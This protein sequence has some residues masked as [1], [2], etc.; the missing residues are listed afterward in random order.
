ML[1]GWLAVGKSLARPPAR[2]PDGHIGPASRGQAEHAAGGRS[3][4]APCCSDRVRPLRLLLGALDPP[5]VALQEQLPAH[6]AAV[7]G[8]Q[9]LELVPELPQQLPVH[10]AQLQQLNLQELG[11]VQD[12]APPLAVD[13]LNEFHVRGLELRIHLVCEDF[14]IVPVHEEVGEGAQGPP[15]EG[16]ADQRVDAREEDVP[17][18]PCDGLQASSAARADRKVEAHNEIPLLGGQAEDDPDKHPNEKEGPDHDEGGVLR[19]EHLHLLAGPPRLVPG[20]LQVLD[21]HLAALQAPGLVSLLNQ[22]IHHLLALLV[23]HLPESSQLRLDV[24]IVP[25]DILEDV[26]VE[27][28]VADHQLPQVVHLH[29]LVP[30]EVAR[31]NVLGESLLILVLLAGVPRY[32]QRYEEGQHAANNGGPHQNVEHGVQAASV[33]GLRKQPKTDG[34]P[35]LDCVVEALRDAPPAHL[36]LDLLSSCTATRVRRAIVSNSVDHSADQQPQKDNDGAHGQGAP[37]IRH[38]GSSL[39]RLSRDC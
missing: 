9:L 7:L 38:A 11:L 10:V 13:M 17:V 34:K 16:H 33:R 32:R 31:R 3:S 39:P 20:P 24:R 6:L 25:L 12:V 37:F 5:L 35:C 36:R 26:S 27:R 23:F 4:T 19:E 1:A 2:S 21:R 29:A 22:G 30:V 28:W 14:G 8:V 18:V 15:I